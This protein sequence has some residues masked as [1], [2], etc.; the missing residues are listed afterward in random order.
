MT[1]RPLV[2]LGGALVAIGLAACG[3]GGGGGAQE[4]AVAPPA[5]PRTP[6][7]RRRDAACEQIQPRL[8]ACAVEDARATLSADQLAT[9]KPD[10]LRAAHRSEFLDQ[11]RGSAMS[12]RQVRVLE[13]CFREETA[14]GPLAACLVHL[15]PKSA[16]AP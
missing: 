6:L 16:P 3:G 15:A 5:D 1:A 11:C 7:E 8:T 9:L 10:E 13:V 14:C 12:S 4:P 2:A